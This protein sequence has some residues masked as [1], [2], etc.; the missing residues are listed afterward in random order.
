MEVASRG[1]SQELVELVLSEECVERV[2]P[3]GG[4]DEQ[5]DTLEEGQS[6]KYRHTYSFNKQY[7]H[8]IV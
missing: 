6:A 2:G 8:T 5:R 3:L 7:L 4:R 1:V